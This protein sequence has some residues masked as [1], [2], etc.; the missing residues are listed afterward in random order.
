MHSSAY[1]PYSVAAPE[2]RAMSE[3]MLGEPCSSD[4]VPTRKNLKFTNIT[5]TS[6]MNSTRPCTIMFSMPVSTPGSGQP[7]MSP[8]EM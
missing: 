7:N 6:S 5:G 1:M 2:P 3:S 8:M 4:F